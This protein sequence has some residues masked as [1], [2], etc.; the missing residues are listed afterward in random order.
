MRDGWELVPLGEVSSQVVEPVPV[1]PDETY[2][3]LG[4]RMYAGGVFEREAKRGSEIKAKRLFRVR[5][6]QF[7]YNR[8]FAG[9]GS[10]GLVKAEHA[11]G[12]VSNE[13]PVFDLNADR[14]LPAYLYL[15]FQRPET[16]DAVAEQC[17]GTTQTRL[18]WKEDRFRA[19]AIA[20][21][22]LDEQRRIVDLIGAL[23]DAIEAA[24]RSADTARASRSYLLEGLMS[25][26]GDESEVR[27]LGEVGTFTPGRRFTKA[28]YV[29]RGLGCIHYGQIY[30]HLG[31]VT[32]EPLTF[33]PESMR[34]KLRLAAHGDVVI[35]ATSENIEDV[36]KATV[37]LG[38]GDVAVHDDCRIFRHSLDPRFATHLFATE[39]F[40]RQKVQYAAGTKVTRISAND[41][42]RIQLPIPRPEEQVAIGESMSNLDDVIDGL[43]D[44]RT[45]LL[46][47][48]SN[49]LTALL[50]GQHEIPKTYDESLEA[51]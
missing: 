21:P 7:I 5:P 1:L 16:W 43:R 23:D 22:P 37:W 30:T 40:Q 6:G 47:L 2:S 49:L 35:A 18:R 39:S 17:I 44:Q 15:H 28:D 41:L 31:S 48:R 38:D 50:S 29:E 27:P 8:L 42:A 13:F 45:Q 33:V 25:Q 46:A 20:L 19:Y 3:N 32:T 51:S 26:L 11:H 10:F 12:V 9:G 4:L 34:S 14:L 36:G 24:E